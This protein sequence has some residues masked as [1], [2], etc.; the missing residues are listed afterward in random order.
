MVVPLAIAALLL[1]ACGTEDESLVTGS[2]SGD[3]YTVTLAAD[4]TSPPTTWRLECEP[5]GGDHP[6]AAAACAAIKAAANPFEPVPADMACTE[7]YGGPGVATVSGVR[8]GKRVEARYTRTNGCEI[9]RWDA[10]G[11][12]IPR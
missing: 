11:A 9:S 8:Q 7:I 2:G 6:D 12:V 10:I 4:D 5:A 1:A 3:T